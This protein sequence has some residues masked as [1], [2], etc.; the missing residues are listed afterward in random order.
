MLPPLI[1]QVEMSAIESDVRWRRR[2][3]KAMGGKRRCLEVPNL[4]V[5]RP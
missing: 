2:Q 5:N 1:Q 3:V 4:G